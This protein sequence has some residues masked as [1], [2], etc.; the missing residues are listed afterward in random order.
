MLSISK[1]QQK[2]SNP[3][4]NVGKEID[5][6]CEIGLSW[7]FKL[8][9]PS[10]PW[11]SHVETN[12][13]LMWSEIMTSRLSLFCLALIP[14]FSHLTC[15]DQADGP[16]RE[17]LRKLEKYKPVLNKSFDD[18]LNALNE[19]GKNGRAANIGGPRKIRRVVQK[20]QKPALRP[21]CMYLKICQ[22]SSMKFS[23]LTSQK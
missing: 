1:Q 6:Q 17:R 21:L 12:L 3:T 14:L 7:K 8:Q 9:F 20:F 10:P 2:E 5:K 16:V 23:Q 19:R 4:E 18:M 11:K 13:S 22:I 15:A